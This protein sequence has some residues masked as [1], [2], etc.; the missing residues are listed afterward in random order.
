MTT[1]L[2]QQFI[3]CTQCIK[4]KPE[5]VSPA[6][7]ARYEVGVTEEGHLQV[8]CP[9]HEVNIGIF[10]V[11]RT[12]TTDPGGKPKFATDGV[13]TGEQRRVAEQLVQHAIDNCLDWPD[14]EEVGLEEGDSC[15]YIANTWLNNEVT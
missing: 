6:E 7:W 11:S 1:K 12:V 14:P 13:L 8:W 2:I 15:H 10:E 3:H 4:D 5:G 9:R